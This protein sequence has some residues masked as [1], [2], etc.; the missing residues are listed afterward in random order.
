MFDHPV[1]ATEQTSYHQI[2]ALS[3]PAL[4]L[5]FPGRTGSSLLEWEDGDKGEGSDWLHCRFD[6]PHDAVQ[7]SGTG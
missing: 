1:P 4:A 3:A 7:E 5:S 6:S 2:L